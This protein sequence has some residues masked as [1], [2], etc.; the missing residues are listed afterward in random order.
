MG[1][2]ALVVTQDTWVVRVSKRTATDAAALQL[3]K[4]HFLFCQ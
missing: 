2:S 1:R 3:A 4:E